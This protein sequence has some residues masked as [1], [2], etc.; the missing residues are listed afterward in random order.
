MHFEVAFRGHP[1][2][3]SLHTRT[4]EITRKPGLT[5]QGDCIVGV[6]A[7]SGC[8]GLPD[9]LKTL[10]RNSGALVRITI[11][12][13]NRTFV[14]RGRG[15]P[16]LDLS[17]PDDMV[18]R[19]SSFVCPRTLAVGCSVASDSLPREMVRDLQSP[20]AVGTMIISVA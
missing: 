18:I 8:L 6:C 12:V 20:D 5:L 14:I 11:A 4:V 9:E 1:N 10:L 19:T 16:G 2:I 3:R 13:G 15:D 7:S 17:H